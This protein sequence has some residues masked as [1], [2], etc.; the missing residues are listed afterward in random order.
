MRILDG[1]KNVDI[2]YLD[3]AN[4]FD[5]VPHHRLIGKMA[6]MGVEGKVKGWIHQWL[7]G[8]KQRVING[9][10]SDWTD[11]S[12]GVPQGSVLG[13]T[14]FLMLINNLEEGV[15]GRVLKFADDTKL[16]S[17]VTKEEGGEQLQEDLDK[18]SKC[19]VAKC[20]VLHA[21]RTNRRK[22]YMMEGK[23]I[24][25]VQEEKDLG[26]VVHRV[27]NGSRQVAEAV[28]KANCALALIR[29]TIGNTEIDTVVPMDKATVRPHLEYCIQSWASYLKKDTNALEQVQHRATKMVTSLRKLS[30]EQ[31]LKKCRLTTL[32]ERRRRGDLLETHKIMHGLER[33]PADRFFA[34]ADTLRRG[35]S[36]KLFKERSRHEP[37]RNFFSQRVVSPWNALPDK[38]VS[39]KTTLPRGIG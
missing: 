23:I 37:R 10:V 25:K 17:E 1:G 16:Y 39:S 38:V 12:S 20:K 30:Y 26:V 27:V 24:E 29:R 4:A 31:R 21:G 19:N 6:A 11:V 13:P 9:S 2:V 35:H 14:L 34:R 3:F 18:I 33:I 5:K 32:E 8:R 7:E 22:G 15:Q 36:M 28:K